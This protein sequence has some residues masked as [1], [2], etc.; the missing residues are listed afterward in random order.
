MHVCDLSQPA[1]K[2]QASAILNFS[3]VTD[4]CQQIAI[5]ITYSFQVIDNNFLQSKKAYLKLRSR[6][7]ETETSKLYDCEFVGLISLRLTLNLLRMFH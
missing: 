5:C 6:D 7:T 1:G 4:F 2:S 3:N